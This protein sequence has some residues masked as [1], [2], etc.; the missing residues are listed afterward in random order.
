MSTDTDRPDE[1]W[2]LA[3]LGD[4]CSWGHKKLAVHVW[5]FGHALNLTRSKQKK[6]AEWQIWKDKYVPGLGHSSEHRYRTLAR[7]LAEESLEGIGLTDAYR[8]LEL[9]GKPAN[10]KTRG[11]P[12]ALAPQPVV[13]GGGRVPPTRGG[14]V[15]TGADDAP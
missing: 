7:S 12:F 9:T 15:A 3:R 10:G 4:F 6:R 8:L 11:V 14:T 13:A 2:S 1:N 5:R